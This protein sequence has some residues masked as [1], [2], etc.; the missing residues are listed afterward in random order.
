[1]LVRG[2]AHALAEPRGKDAKVLVVGLKFKYLLS[3]FFFFLNLHIKFKTYLS[4]MRVCLM[5]KCNSE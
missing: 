5:R 2:I 4:K 1:M 3:F